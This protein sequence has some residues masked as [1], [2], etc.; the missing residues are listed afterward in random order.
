MLNVINI[1]FGNNNNNKVK[2]IYNK[3]D[4]ILVRPQNIKYPYKII[5]IREKKISIKDNIK[6]LKIPNQQNLFTLNDIFSVSNFCNPSQKLNANLIS[7]SSVKDSFNLTNNFINKTSK[8]NSDMDIRKKIIEVEKLKQF[9]NNENIRYSIRQRNFDDNFFLKHKG[10]SYSNSKY[11]ENF[12]KDKNKDSKIKTNYIIK[13]ENEKIFNYDSSVINNEKNKNCYKLKYDKLISSLIINNSDEKNLILKRNF[14]N[15]KSLK[16]IQ[17]RNDKKNHIKRMKLTK[18]NKDLKLKRQK[19]MGIERI[20]PQEKIMFK[21]KRPFSTDNRKKN[22]R[23]NFELKN[24]RKYRIEEN[25]N[26]IEK[27]NKIK[28]YQ[29]RMKIEKELKSLELKNGY[30]NNIN[31]TN[32]IKHNNLNKII[33]FKTR[34][35]S[36]IFD[37]IVI[38]QNSKE[39]LDNKEK[40]NKKDFTEFKSVVNK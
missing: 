25:K 23:I 7:N 22:T 10:L 34:K 15:V 1:K 27:E 17:Y 4:I 38:P 6:I 32:N 11:F 16:Q 40:D 36:D 26:L 39:A 35:N 31:K 20:K 8:K 9:N 33:R 24:S 12:T 37:Y 14:D 13:E 18:S 21:T 2:K 19:S 5:A 29:K 28:K 30:L 3:G